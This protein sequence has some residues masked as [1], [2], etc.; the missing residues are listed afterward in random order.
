MRETSTLQEPETSLELSDSP[1]AILEHQW[2]LSQDVLNKLKAEH[3]DPND[4]FMTL[5]RVYPYALWPPCIYNLQF[6]EEVPLPVAEVI[7]TA[8][9]QNPEA[10]MHL[11]P[12]PAEDSG[13]LEDRWEQDLQFMVSEMQEVLL[14]TFGISS[15]LTED[16]LLEI[17]EKLTKANKHT[18]EL[19]YFSR[20][21][22]QAKVLLSEIAPKL[23]PV[24]EQCV[25][26]LIICKEKPPE[27]DRKLL[28]MGMPPPR[29]PKHL[30]IIG[31]G[32]V[33]ESAEQKSAL[34]NFQPLI[35]RLQ[36]NAYVRTTIGS[37]LNCSPQMALPENIELHHF[38]NVVVLAHE[39]LH[40]VTAH[41]IKKQI[42]IPKAM[43][44][45]K[46]K[47]KFAGSLSRM[48]EEGISIAGETEIAH[49]L[50]RIP[51]ISTTDKASLEEFLTFR[52]NDHR[53]NTSFWKLSVRAAFVGD[54]DPVP[55]TGQI[56]VLSYS[57][58]TL[59]ARILERKGWKLND[60]EDFIDQY[61]S[62][63]KNEFGI[64]NISDTDSIPV[65]K[66]QELGWLFQRKTSKYLEVRRKIKKLK[67]RTTVA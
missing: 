58:G 6:S 13:P 53:E 54:D 60:I 27:I 11:K 25:D 62:V 61:T 4:Y 38:Q 36:D 63:L 29:L 46:F 64:K 34:E 67:P 10:V 20:T 30:K 32:Q 44:Q 15:G 14:N 12:L 24:L 35:N 18:H 50:L 31:D 51:G 22:N 8:L 28:G 7:L 2:S 3:V 45:K 17:Y 9:K 42:D 49:F 16:A 21:V 40:G 43:R 65:N 26:E 52:E 39:L 56:D 41:L 19:V 48:I 37:Y 33:A 57:E 55:I 23:G 66:Q 5:S 47:K 1:K 59:L